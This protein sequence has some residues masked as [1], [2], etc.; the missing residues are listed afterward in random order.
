[1]SFCLRSRCCSSFPL[2]FAQRWAKGSTVVV[3]NRMGHKWNESVEAVVA[4]W[5]AATPH[6]R[7]R[8]EHRKG[9]CSHWLGTGRIIFCDGGVGPSGWDG[10]MLDWRG[11]ELVASL[12]RI[13]DDDPTNRYILCHEFGHAIGL[14][15]NRAVG[16]SCLADYSEDDPI[17]APGPFDRE[18][19]RLLY[20]RDGPKWP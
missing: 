15:H 5:D 1:V 7:F 8:V 3:E 13:Q 14:M 2:I 9:G 16:E 11:R 17:S 18:S 6:L 12:I 10:A 19:L 20:Q 4:A